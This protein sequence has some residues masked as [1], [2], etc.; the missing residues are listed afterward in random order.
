MFAVLLSFST[1]CAITYLVAFILIWREYRGKAPMVS[2][3]LWFGH[4]ALYWNSILIARIFFGYEGPSVFVTLWG[5]AVFL[6]G[7]LAVIFH[8]AA[9]AL[10]TRQNGREL[11]RNGCG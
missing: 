7:S 8:F 2:M 9:K 5:G 11:H 6:H 4:C 3:T 1:L 10:A